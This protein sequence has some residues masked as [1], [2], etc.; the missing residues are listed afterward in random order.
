[1]ARVTASTDIDQLKPE[2]VQKFVDLAL[3]DIVTQVNGE[4]TIGE[5]IKARLV[6]VTF[7]AANTDVQVSHTLGKIAQGYLVY[8]SSA[9]TSIYNGSSGSTASAIFLRASA[10]ATV[11]LVIF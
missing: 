1:M 11:G 4:L 7:S 9:A 6:S 8:S 2:E 3:Q 10:P 5:N